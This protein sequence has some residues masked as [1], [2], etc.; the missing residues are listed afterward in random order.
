M[1]TVWNGKRNLRCHYLASFLVVSILSMITTNGYSYSSNIVALRNHNG[2]LHPMRSRSRNRLVVNH[3]PIAAKDFAFVRYMTRQPQQQD[4]RP[5]KNTKKRLD[6]QHGFHAGNFAD[7]FKHVILIMLL[8]H[9]QQAKKGKPMGYVESHAG[10]GL[11][12]LPLPGDDDPDYCE[13]EFQRG[14]GKLMS[15]LYNQNKKSDSNVGHDNESE[16]ISLLLKDPAVQ[17]YLEIV[18]SFQPNGEQPTS[19]SSSEI[20]VYPGSPLFAASMLLQNHPANEMLLYEKAPSQFELLQGHLQAFVDGI[21]SNDNSNNDTVGKNQQEEN[22]D[23]T[24][25]EDNSAASTASSS[26]QVYCDNGYTQLA[27]HAASTTKLPPRTL[28]LVDPPYQLGSDTEQT[29][30]LCQKLQ[31]HWR[32][33]RIAIWH[34]VR[35]GC[36]ATAQRQRLYQQL[37]QQ[38]KQQQ[39]PSKSKANSK[40]AAAVEMLSIEIFPPRLPNDNGSKVDDDTGDATSSTSSTTRKDDVGTGMILIQPPFGMEEACKEVLPCLYRC[41][42]PNDDGEPSLEDAIRFEWLS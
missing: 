42:S 7:V 11:Y 10:A 22:S 6:Y 9:M 20:L 41:L 37:L 33:A 32:T 35:H 3:S 36:E 31:R 18:Q 24:E 38:L 23:Q 29:V 2:V 8:Q 26:Y 14:I 13:P 1:T 34:P 4:Q 17:R 25:K 27:Y 12:Q 15:L 28:I 19:S 39:Q 21:I 40:P 16:Q 30:A 5:T